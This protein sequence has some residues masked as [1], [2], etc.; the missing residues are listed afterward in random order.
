MR[1]LDA[2]PTLSRETVVNGDRAPVL[3][4]AEHVADQVRLRSDLF[5]EIMGREL[6][7]FVSC[8][9][10]RPRDARGPRAQR[11]ANRGSRYEELGLIP[12]DRWVAEGLCHSVGGGIRLLS[13]FLALLRQLVILCYENAGG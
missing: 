13:F 7:P 8:C 9:E 12:G 10:D 1:D 3:R 2:F 5:V 6:G 11:T 4:A